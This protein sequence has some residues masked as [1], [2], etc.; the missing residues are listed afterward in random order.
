MHVEG[1]QELSKHHG[2]RKRAAV[3]CHLQHER[4]KLCKNK[5]GPKLGRPIFRHIL[6]EELTVFHQERIHCSLHWVAKLLVISDQLPAKGAWAGKPQG[7]PGV[8]HPHRSGR[9]I[10]AADHLLVHQVSGETPVG[11]HL[12]SQEWEVFH[13]LERAWAAH[14]ELWACYFRMVFRVYLHRLDHLLYS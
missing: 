4:S 11:I 3:G 6:N 14:W 2:G 12:A 9:G 10:L 1:Y 13:W 7:G 5:N 8:H